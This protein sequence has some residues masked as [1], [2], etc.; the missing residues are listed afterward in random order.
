V[1]QLSAPDSCASE[2]L[3]DPGVVEC[4]AC[5]ARFDISGPVPLSRSA[6][7]AQERYRRAI[8]P[9]REIEIRACNHLITFNGYQY[10]VLKRFLCGDCREE[11]RLEEE[12]QRSLATARM[13]VREQEC[14]L[15]AQR[16]MENK[17]LS[18]WRRL[19][20]ITICMNG[21]DFER[22]RVM[23]Y[24]NFLRTTYWGIVRAQTIKRA[25]FACQLCNQASRLEVHHRTYEHHGQEHDWYSNDL[26]VLCNPCHAKFHNKLP[27]PPR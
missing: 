23:P 5:A 7:A 26:I 18:P 21:D 10:D 3:S 15:Q 11:Y 20:A 1:S 9:D 16:D 19:E 22:L 6:L 12:H 17:H 8:G 25:G 24:R 4:V 27:A 13:K 14:F 2:H